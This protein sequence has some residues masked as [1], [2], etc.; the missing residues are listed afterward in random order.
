MKPTDRVALLA[1]GQVTRLGDRWF[2]VLL[3]HPKGAKTAWYTQL[4]VYDHRYALH[5]E[6]MFTESSISPDEVLIE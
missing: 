4:M 6:G 3:I 2:I 1:V 5:S